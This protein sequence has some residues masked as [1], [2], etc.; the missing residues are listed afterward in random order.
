MNQ[1]RPLHIGISAL[2]VHPAR[3]GGAETYARRLLASL[4]DFDEVNQYTVFVPR[5]GDLALEQENFRIVELPAPVENVYRRV[6]WE[7]L[8]QRRHL[9][10]YEVELMH[11]PTSTAPYGYRG[12][13]VV[14][15]HDTIRYQRPELA[16]WH[17]AKYYDLVQRNI[18]RTGKHVIG[19]S[20]VDTDVMR[21]QLGLREEQVSVVY[22]GV[23]ATFF[24][25]TPAG[26]KE[27]YLLW[28]GRP[29]PHKNVDHLLRVYGVLNRRGRDLPRLRLVGAGPADQS[30]LGRMAEELGVRELISLEGRVAH[31]RL[32]AV[33]AKA[34]LLCFPSK[35]ES[36]GLPV[37][38]AMASGTAVLCS[39]LPCF[40]EIFADAV[41]YSS[42]TSVEEFADALDE[43]LTNPALRAEYADKGRQRASRFTWD[44]CARKTLAV[45]RKLIDRDRECGAVRRPPHNE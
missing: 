10:R 39:E 12:R 30:R 21:R 40:R 32:P 22:N 14:T 17:H 44:H 13:S 41:R 29:Y 5:G 15:I 7:Q 18:A 9:R 1:D 36:F 23:D 4:A 11:F 20:H 38:E 31:E 45:Y 16:A 2:A 25:N 8:F 19:V 34:Q 33:L 3:F 24:Q 28:V 35:Y 26:D 37:L 43:L 6:G 27:D 42:A